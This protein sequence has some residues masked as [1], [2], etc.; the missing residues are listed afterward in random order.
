MY[1]ECAT[2]SASSWRCIFYGVCTVFA[3]RTNRHKA[4]C[5]SPCVNFYARGMFLDVFGCFR[6]FSDVSGG[7]RGSCAARPQA[8][9]MDAT[10]LTGSP[11]HFSA[12]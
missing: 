8:E 5:G 4:T 1:A 9:P 6:M 7:L 10:G 3:K 12:F 11:V 2:I